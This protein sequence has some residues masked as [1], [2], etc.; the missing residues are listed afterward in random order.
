MDV[1][2]VMVEGLDCLSFFILRFLGGFLLFFCREHTTFIVCECRGLHEWITQTVLRHVN[3]TMNLLQVLITL[4]K[5]GKNAPF[6]FA[7][8]FYV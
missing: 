1:V 3:C 7:F 5:M 6:H 2:I 4:Q 8:F